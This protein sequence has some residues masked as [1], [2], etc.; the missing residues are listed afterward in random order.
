MVFCDTDRSEADELKD[1]YA[2]SLEAYNFVA[3][4]QPSPSAPY[5]SS[6]RD[7]VISRIEGGDDIVCGIFHN[8]DSAGHSYEFSVSNNEYSNAVSNCDLYAYQV[9]QVI[10][11]RMITKNGSLFSQMTMAVSIR[12]MGSRLLRSAQPGLQR[13]FRL[14]KVFIPQDMTDTM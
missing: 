6:I 14:T 9:L 12:G 11:R 13:I 5:D 10:V 3:P 1:T 7:W 2:K 4:E 8:I